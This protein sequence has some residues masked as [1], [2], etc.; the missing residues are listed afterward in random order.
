MKKKLLVGL[1]TVSA[2][3]ALSST[4][5]AA[6]APTTTSSFSSSNISQVVTPLDFE[7]NISVNVGETIWVTG[8]DFWVVRNPE[9]V[10]VTQDGSITGLQ[11]GVSVV[12]ADFGNDQVMFYTVTIN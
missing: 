6:N 8:Y 10:L 11:H 4:S 2:C 12:A 5:F 3:F 9:N 1:L 7:A